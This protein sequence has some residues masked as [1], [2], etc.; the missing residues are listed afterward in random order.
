VK[1]VVP[2]GFL[3][4]PWPHVERVV[5]VWFLSWPWPHVERDMVMCPLLSFL[6]RRCIPVYQTTR[7]H[8]AI[9]GSDFLISNFLFPVEVHVA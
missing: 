2:V 3:S 9:S 1:R 6:C 4:W 5:P 7:C 8:I